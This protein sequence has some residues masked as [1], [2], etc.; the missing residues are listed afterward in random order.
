MARYP[1]RTRGGLGSVLGRLGD[2]LGMVWG[3]SGD[4]LGMVWAGFGDVLVKLPER[5]NEINFL[6]FD[7]EARFCFKPL[8]EIIFFNA[9]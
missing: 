3:C 2:D 7:L 8:F 4:A 5:E 6:D 9:F 1:A